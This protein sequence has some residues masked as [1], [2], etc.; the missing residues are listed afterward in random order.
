MK[1]SNGGETINRN[2][3]MKLAQLV[4]QNPTIQQINGAFDSC[5]FNEK[6]VYIAWNVFHKQFCVETYSNIVDSCHPN[7]TQ[8]TLVDDYPLFQ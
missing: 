7:L 8:A 4:G 3:V 1:L 6:N 2:Q 5:E